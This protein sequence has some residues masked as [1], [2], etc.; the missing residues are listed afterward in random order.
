MLS[1]EYS[2][3]LTIYLYISLINLLYLMLSIEM[4]LS[5][6]HLFNMFLYLYIYKN[7]LGQ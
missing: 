3:H 2:F 4:F 5:I 7:L 1:I 6:Y